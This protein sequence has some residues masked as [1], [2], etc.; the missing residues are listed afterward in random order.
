MGILT[1]TSDMTRDDWLKHRRAGIGGSDV[2]AIL[3]M[4]PWRSPFDVYLDKIGESEPVEETEAMY[5][6]TMLEEVVAQEFAKRTGKKLRRRNAIF[7]DDEI[8][9]LLANIDRDVVGEDAILECKTTS[10]YNRGDW[11]QEGTDEIPF[12]YILQCQHYLRVTGN[13]MAHVAALIGGNDFRVYEVQRNEE[14]ISSIVERCVDFWH[15]VTMRIPPAPRSLADVEKLYAAGGKDGRVFSD[16]CTEFACAEIQRL[17]DDEKRIAEEREELEKQ[18]KEAMGESCELVRAYDD[19][20]LCT[21]KAS[22][23]RR[24]DSTRFKADHAEL[25]DQYTRESTSRRF[26]IKSIKE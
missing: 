9:F 17:R 1:Y 7:Q 21:W 13:S 25:Y 10:A 16:E 4:N 8:P 15:R 23:S 5:W 19:Q 26:I 12:P 18:V 6:G 2:A 3:G 11:G 24:F 22:T 20:T 14:L